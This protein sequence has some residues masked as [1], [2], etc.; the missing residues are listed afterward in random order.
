MDE[1]EISVEKSTENQFGVRY[2]K[3]GG[4]H[5]FVIETGE[6]FTYGQTELSLQALR[7]NA[8]AGKKRARNLCLMPFFCYKVRGGKK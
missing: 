5:S 3:K 1:K 2:V 6:K 8:F 4:E 7:V